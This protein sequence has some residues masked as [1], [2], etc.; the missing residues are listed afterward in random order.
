MSENVKEE[1][2]K[3]EEESQGTEI[4]KE[5]EAAEK[6]EAEVKAKET[7][8][9]KETDPEEPSAPEKH[10]APK[11]GLMDRRKSFEQSSV[12]NAHKGYSG[13]HTIVM[14]LIV[15]AMFIVSYILAAITG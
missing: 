11:K 14:L 5:A 8:G 1:T 10:E 4:K 7:G 9:E 15:V 13:K 2:K 12:P 6:V 3:I